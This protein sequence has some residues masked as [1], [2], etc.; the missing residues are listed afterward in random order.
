[1]IASRAKNNVPGP[2]D[3]GIDMTFRYSSQL[4]YRATTSNDEKSSKQIS[5]H[6]PGKH[7]S[8]ELH[9]KPLTILPSVLLL[10]K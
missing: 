10:T 7:S 4:L 3:S 1:M 2:I 5:A 8:S 9:S 6:L